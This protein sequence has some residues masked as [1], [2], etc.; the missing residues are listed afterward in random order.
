MA[1]RVSSIV[2]AETDLNPPV[3]LVENPRE[4]E[5]LVSNFAVDT[6]RAQ[7]D[8]G[9]EPRHTID[10]SIQQLVRNRLTTDAET[11]EAIN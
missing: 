11:A 3:K 7:A 1:E 9:W 5:P 6:T 8:L 10:D 4:G 2:A